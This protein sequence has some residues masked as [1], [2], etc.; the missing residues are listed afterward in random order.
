MET[1]AIEFYH[2]HAIW[3]PLQTRNNTKQNKKAKFLYFAIDAMTSYPHPRQALLCRGYKY[4]QKLY[5]HLFW[6]SY[7]DIF[8]RLRKKG[9]M[10][11]IGWSPCSPMNMSV[12]IKEFLVNHYYDKRERLHIYQ[13]THS[14]FALCFNDFTE[15]DNNCQNSN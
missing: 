6:G 14:S 10:K 7:A 11:H 4:S 9:H 12:I 5:R 2:M 8:L 1:R 13:R 15:T 3:W